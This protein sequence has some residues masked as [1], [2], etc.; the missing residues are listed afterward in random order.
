MNQSIVPGLEPEILR[1]AI[2][3]FLMTVGCGSLFSARRTHVTRQRQF[4]VVVHLANQSADCH[5]TCYES[6]PQTCAG[7][8]DVQLFDT[9]AESNI[10]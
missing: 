2:T 10:G 4:C 3:H 8:R 6:V 1:W 9:A 7:Q 5:A